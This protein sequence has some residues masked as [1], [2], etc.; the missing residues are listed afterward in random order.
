VV[1]VV[2]RKGVARAR[3]VERLSAG[4]W[5]LRGRRMVVAAPAELRGLV[6]VVVVVPFSFLLPASKEE[7][8]FF[9]FFSSATQ[10]AYWCG[11]AG[12]TKDLV[13][14]MAA[15]FSRSE[16]QASLVELG[17][18]VVVGGGIGRKKR[19][20]LEMG[21]KTKGTQRQRQRQRCNGR[22]EW[23]V[24]LFHHLSKPTG[25]HALYIGHLTSVPGHHMPG[26]ATRL[27]LAVGNREHVE[28][29]PL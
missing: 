19:F 23:Q 6:V 21:T 11:V 15:I 27:L 14:P 5:P 17:A 13:Q 20:A 4:M 22:N 2:G 29:G 7:P 10:P 12:S 16:S 3:T 24:A 9:F 26:K 25:H 8:D 1:V 28:H 18:I